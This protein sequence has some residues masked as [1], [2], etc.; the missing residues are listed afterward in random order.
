MGL[1]GDVEEDRL[2]PRRDRRGDAVHVESEVRIGV[3]EH[4]HAAGER[5]HRRVADEVRIEQDHLVAGVDGREQR[6]NQG[7]AGAA[8]Q[9]HVAVGVAIGAIEPTP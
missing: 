8:G 4:R 7:P 6:Q 9:D 3:D 1:A 2:R 5:D